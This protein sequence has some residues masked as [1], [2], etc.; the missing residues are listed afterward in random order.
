MATTLDAIETALVAALDAKRQTAGAALTTAR[1][2]RSVTR[3]SGEGAVEEIVQAQAGVCPS[4]L[5]VY[6]GSDNITGRGGD[7]YVETA[8]SDVEVVEDHHFAVYVTVADARGD[9]AVVKGGTKT[10]GILTCSHAVADA[11]AGLRVS[12]LK[13][14]GVVHL[15]SRRPLARSAS[16]ATHVLRFRARAALAATT[17]TL[18]GVPLSRVDTT[19]TDEDTT[20]ESATVTLATDRTSTT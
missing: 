7:D 19:V 18:P 11:L 6:V 13:A 20:T 17:E 15:V 16:G 2:F 3:W 9:T 10:P 1:P 12:G 14:G 4:A 8:A 5:L